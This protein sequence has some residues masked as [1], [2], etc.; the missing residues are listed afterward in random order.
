MSAVRA[1]ADPAAAVGPIRPAPLRGGPL[2]ATVAPAVHARWPSDRGAPATA[3]SARRPATAARLRRHPRLR[4][5]VRR[6]WVAVAAASEAAAGPRRDDGVAAACPPGNGPMHRYRIRAEM[7]AAPGPAATRAATVPQPNPASRPAPRVFRATNRPV[8][9]S[10]KPRP[11]PL[12]SGPLPGRRR[13]TAGAAA[14]RAAFAARLA[15]RRP[16]VEPVCR[17]TAPRWPATAG[18]PDRRGRGVRVVRPPAVPP[19]DAPAAAPIRRSADSPRVGAAVR[20][21]AGDDTAP[22]PGP[23]APLDPAA[24][25]RRGSDAGR[26][27]EFAALRAAR[28]GPRAFPPARPAAARES[29]PRD[30]PR[31]P[32]PPPVAGV[33]L[34]TGPRR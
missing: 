28:T 33:L 20:A 27:A 4:A 26:R 7:P 23:P 9:G 19:R 21:P 31:A 34:P 22:R 32:A 24:A 3:D 2:A 16:D 1:A 18:R 10:E 13:P 17:R 30:S 11:A 5:A 29:M 15:A 25:H 14:D 8:A 6:P 12:R